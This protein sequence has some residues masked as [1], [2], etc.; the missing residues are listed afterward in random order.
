MTT[1]ETPAAKTYSEFRDELLTELGERIKATQLQITNATDG[2]NL[3][4]TKERHNA[5]GTDADVNRQI[6]HQVGQ[7]QEEIRKC[8]AQLNV[9]EL[10]REGLVRG[11]DPR[12]YTVATTEGQVGR[13]ARQ[14]E[15][16]AALSH[17]NELA[18]RDGEF[19]QAARR[20]VELTAIGI[21]PPAIALAVVNAL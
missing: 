21:K 9:L 1:T 8:R 13:A 3:Q 19:V 20:V 7:Y 16:A 11:T 15:Y 2:I 12:L 14:R 17:F 10:E 6:Q 5:Y 4:R 18:R